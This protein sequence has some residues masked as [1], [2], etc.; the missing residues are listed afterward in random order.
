MKIGKFS[1][2]ILFSHGKAPSENLLG[3]TDL[4]EKSSA[5]VAKRRE[6]VRKPHG[7]LF[8]PERDRAAARPRGVVT[9]GNQLTEVAG[10]LHSKLVG[11]AQLP[12]L[13]STHNP[14]LVYLK[15]GACVT[16]SEE[17]AI[18]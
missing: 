1:P 18:E 17:T 15:V 3:R 12:L 6:G 2:R 16:P 13:H 10:C 4:E 14:R 9:A 7:A 11:L 8:S 5:D